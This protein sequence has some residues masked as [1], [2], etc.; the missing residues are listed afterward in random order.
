MPRGVM[1]VYA[2]RASAGFRSR[3]TGPPTTSSSTT[4]L[5]RV[6]LSTT[7]SAS[8]LIVSRRSGAAE[9][10]SKTSYHASDMPVCW[11]SNRSITGTSS[12]CTRSSEPHAS[13][14][15]LLRLCGITAPYRE[16]R[17]CALS[18][19]VRTHIIVLTRG[20]RHAQAA[21]HLRLAARRRFG[22][23]RDRRQLPVRRTRRPTGRGRLTLES[24]GRDAA[25]VRS[26]SGGGQD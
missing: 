1:V 15:S 8:A 16:L 9:S 18:Y 23:A 14:A 11:T 4:R 19:Y 26:R 7:R 6:R 22:V 21:A 5:T 10:S 12:A 17:A 2:D 3:R 20:G 13:A 24:L 25:G